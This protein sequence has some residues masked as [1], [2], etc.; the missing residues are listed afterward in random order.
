MIK[1]TKMSPTYSN[2]LL[3]LSVHEDQKKFVG[4]IS[5]ALEATT[6][7]VHMHLVLADDL[8]VGIFLVDLSYP[9][10]YEFSSLNSLGLRAYMIDARHQGKGFGTTAIKLLPAYLK[11]TYAEHSQIFLTVNCRNPVAHRCYL[12]GGFIDT[13]QL[14][15]GGAAGPQ[16][17][18]KLAFA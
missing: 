3:S 4:T 18:M 17:I 15:L 1:I 5:D 14:Y 7:R 6:D 11:E 8:V 2:Q 10:K 16:H 9:E 13:E 12:N